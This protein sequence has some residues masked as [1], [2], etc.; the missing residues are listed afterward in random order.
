M[1]ARADRDA[2]DTTVECPPQDFPLH[3]PSSLPSH[4]PCDAKLLQYE[5]R[6]REAQA[7][8]A[9]EDVRQYLRLRTH[10]YKYKNRHVV[11]KYNQ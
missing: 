1:R 7:Y 8:E 5:F 2:S 3:L 10:M 11:A 6:L 9:L 4:T